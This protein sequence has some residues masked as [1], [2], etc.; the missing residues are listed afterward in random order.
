MGKL[1]M[2]AAGGC[3]RITVDA[4]VRLV[5]SGEYLKV[6]KLVET[7]VNDSEG[8]I[9]AAVCARITERFPN[10]REGQPG[11]LLLS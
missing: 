4:V 3:K 7:G 9:D 2:F 5:L 1:R 6:V 10:V 11:T 8:K